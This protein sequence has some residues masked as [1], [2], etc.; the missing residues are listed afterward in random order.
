ML[1][2]PVTSRQK[3]TSAT[4]DDFTKEDADNLYALFKLTEIADLIKLSLDCEQFFTRISASFVTKRLACQINTRISGA[5]KTRIAKERYL[6]LLAETATLPK[7]D[8]DIMTRM[9]KWQDFMSVRPT[10]ASAVAD[11]LNEL[12]QL[13][14]ILFPK[15]MISEDALATHIAAKRARE[16]APAGGAGGGGGG[17]PSLRLSA[18]RRASTKTTKSAPSSSSSAAKKP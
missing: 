12:V 10:I 2:G 15:K 1:D 6:T 16:S 14:N 5:L 7:T 4:T 13:S 17:T 18:T 8:G 11:S 9:T 3:S